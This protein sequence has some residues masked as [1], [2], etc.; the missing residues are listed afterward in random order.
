[1]TLF[2]YS[3]FGCT[4]W[5]YAFIPYHSMARC[6]VVDN[7]DKPWQWWWKQRQQFWFGKTAIVLTRYATIRASFY[8][9]CSFPRWLCVC[10][11]ESFHLY[12]A[13]SIH[14]WWSDGSCGGFST[15]NICS[16]SASLPVYNRSHFY[17]RRWFGWHCTDIQNAIPFKTF[18]HIFWNLMMWLHDRMKTTLLLLMSYKSFQFKYMHAEDDGRK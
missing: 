18:P 1:M 8:W 14:F 2:I 10:V 11:S 4:W 7:N 12:Y 13:I 16:L 3:S 6:W 15:E 5:L 17:K 9:V